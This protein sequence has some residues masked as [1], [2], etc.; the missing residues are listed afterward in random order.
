MARIV[1]LTLRV[2]PVCY[3]LSWDFEGLDEAVESYALTL[4]EDAFSPGQFNHGNKTKNRGWGCVRPL[5]YLVA[6]SLTIWLF[7]DLIFAAKPVLL[8]KIRIVNAPEFYR[9]SVKF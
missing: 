5:R 9:P 4:D 6:R 1:N 3:E 7:T 2:F 8:E